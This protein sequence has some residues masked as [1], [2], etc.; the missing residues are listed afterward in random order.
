[1]VTILNLLYTVFPTPANDKWWGMS[2]SGFK[3]NCVNTAHRQP[4]D[5]TLIE[6]GKTKISHGSMTCSVILMSARC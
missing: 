4:Q 5:T 1:M 6:V 2:G 3:S